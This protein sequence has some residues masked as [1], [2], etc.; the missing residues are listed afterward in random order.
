MNWFFI[1]LTCQAAFVW[2]VSLF[3]FIDYRKHHLKLHIT[4]ISLS[5]M[6]LTILPIGSLIEQTYPA[7]SWRGITAMTA[8]ALGDFGLLTMLLKRKYVGAIT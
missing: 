1:L 2:G 8:F 3:V 5:Y 4:C 6:L 7:L